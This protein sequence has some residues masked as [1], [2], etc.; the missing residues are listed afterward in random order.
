MIHGVQA[1]IEEGE[2]KLYAAMGFI[3]KRQR[4]V[5]RRTKIHPRIHGR[6]AAPTPLDATTIAFGAVTSGVPANTV[7][8]QR[9][10]AVHKAIGFDAICGMRV[11]SLVMRRCLRRTYLTAQSQ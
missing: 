4:S 11:P 1:D 10:D 5:G 3:P 8:A 2:G 7:C 9:S 6:A